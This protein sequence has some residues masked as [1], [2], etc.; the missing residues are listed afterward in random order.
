MEFEKAAY[1]F[2]AIAHPTRLQ[3]ICALI[4]KDRLTVNELADKTVCEQSLLSH[5]LTG[6]RLRGILKAEKEGQNVFY[7]LKEKN[8]SSV[9]NCIQ[10]CN[11]NM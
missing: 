5:H 9:I 10:H 8:I 2:K 3:V 1:I 11:C 7:S 6:L 4:D